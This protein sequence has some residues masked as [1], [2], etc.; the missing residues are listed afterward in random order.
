M[1]SEH[2]KVVP[3]KQDRLGAVRHLKLSQ[4]WRLDQAMLPAHGAWH[5]LN[6]YPPAVQEP[7]R[8]HGQATQYRVQEVGVAQT[9]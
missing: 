8:K 7:D 2:A 1:L 9:T 4:A 3:Q 5:R 6:R